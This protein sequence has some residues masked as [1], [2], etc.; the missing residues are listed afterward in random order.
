MDRIT[1]VTVCYNA[2]N[3]IAKTMRSVLEQAYSSI[4]YLV[5]DGKSKDRTLREIENCKIKYLHNTI[6]LKI[7]S[8]ED[9]GIYD[10]MNKG[11]D[12][13][14]GKWLLFMNAG[15]SFYDMDVISRVFENHT[16]KGIDAV[17]GD[18]VRIYGNKHILVKGHELET[19]KDGF[20]LPFCHQSIFVRTE[21]LKKMKFDLQYKQAADY[22]FFCLFYLDNK[23]ATYCPIVIS[24][25]LMGGISERNTVRHLEEK[26]S[27]REE[28]GLEKFNFIKKKYLVYR[29]SIRQI[30]KKFFPKLLINWIAEKKVYN[31]NKKNIGNSGN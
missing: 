7:I 3:I 1:I 5:I 30:I 13:A 24:N 16:Y 26:I 9:N 21:I 14:T 11:I 12:R 25:Y 29:L 17:F 28:L 19:I 15:D 18:T 20:P 10:A 2:E 31:E 22:K 4:E 27:I 23:I 6:D 8:E